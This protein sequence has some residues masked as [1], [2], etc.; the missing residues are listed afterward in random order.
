MY[1]NCTKCFFREHCY[2]FGLIENNGSNDEMR[3]FAPSS[4]TLTPSTDKF[5]SVAILPFRWTVAYWAHK[6][7]P[8]NMILVSSSQI[9]PLVRSLHAVP[10]PCRR[11]D[12]EKMFRQ[13]DSLYISVNVFPVSDNP[14]PSDHQ[15][16]DRLRHRNKEEGSF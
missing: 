7:S 12:I 9:F 8:H 10:K 5:R 4:C 2:A 14:R 15:F 13:S 16:L 3:D 6:R 11:G 1:S